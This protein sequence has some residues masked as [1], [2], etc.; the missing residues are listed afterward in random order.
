MPISAATNALLT[1]LCIQRNVFSQISAL[2][3]HHKQAGSDLAAAWIDEGSCMFCITGDGCAARRH[4]CT[5]GHECMHA[6]GCTH[7][8]TIQ[9][10]TQSIKNVRRH[11]LPVHFSMLVA[12]SSTVMRPVGHCWH[13]GFGSLALPP[14]EY[15]PRGLRLQDV[16]QKPGAHAVQD[17]RGLM[18]ACRELRTSWIGKSFVKEKTA[19]HID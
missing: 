8:H 19:A 7:I 10:P 5:G 4:A 12:P 2:P 13:G 6:R 9:L 18:A 16:P 15:R 17:S 1:V 3:R 14:S 11:H